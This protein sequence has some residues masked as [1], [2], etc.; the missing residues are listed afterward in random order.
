MV[1][2]FYGGSNIV[3]GRDL[4][5][6]RIL[7]PLAKNGG[8]TKTH[9]LVNGSPAINAIPSAD[10]GCTGTDQR[11]VPRPIGPGCDIGAFEK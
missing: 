4:T 9:K 11:G 2:F 6:N 10:P 5:L 1:D 7:R 3:P 8:P